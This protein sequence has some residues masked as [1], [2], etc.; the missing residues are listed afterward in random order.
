MKKSFIYL[1]TLTFIFASCKDFLSID[2]YFS[3]E[4]KL[5]SVFAEKRYVEAYLWAIAGEFTDEGSQLLNSYTPGPLATDEA[6]TVMNANAGYNGMQFVLGRVSA[7]NLYSLNQWASMYRVIRKC[8]TILNRIDEVQDMTIVERFK[9]TGNAR[10]MRAYAYYNILLNQGPPILLGDGVIENNE[11]LDFYNRGRC[12]CDEAVEYI[13]SEL[14]EAALYMDATVPILNFGRPTKG[15]AYGLIA[16][17]RLY[18]ASPLFNG[19]DAARRVFGAW[20]RKSDGVH[21]VSQVPDERR[22]ALAAA[23]AKRVMDMGYYRLYTVPAAAP[24]SSSAPK[25]MPANITLDTDYYKPWPEGAAGIDHFKS[26]SEIFNGEAIASTNP[27]FVWARNSATLTNNTRGSFPNTNGGWNGMS[28]TQKVIDAFSMFDGRAINNSSSEYPYSETGFSSSPEYFSEYQLNTNVYNMYINREMR[29]YASIGFTNCYWSLASTTDAVTKNIEYLFDG[30]NG[31]NSS[32]DPLNYPPT[33][34]VIKKFIHPMDAWNGNNARR[35]PKAYAMIRYADILLMY[36]EAL[37]NLTQTHSIEVNGE[38]QTFS[39]DRDAI[40][41]AFN[42]VRHRAGLPGLTNAEL[43]EPSTI[44]RLI[45]RERMVELLFEN[46]RYFDVRRWGKYEESENVMITGMNVEGTA[47]SYF[48]R[49]I[50]NTSLIGAR[51]VHKK[52]HL[53]PLPLD[54]VRRLPLLDQNPGWEE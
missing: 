22:W 13:C 20:K 28:V 5:D 40:R 38:F 39:R 32:S 4:L 49:T 36:A 37:N 29:F 6:F 52:L 34:Y 16:R 51:I 27:E 53:V 31:K 3:D 10:F 42:Q 41:Q 12:T 48:R 44:Q 47:G 54:E 1:I 23:A 14:E 11:T 18:H 19:G 50:P 30:N 35:L 17:L 33:G 15:A 26:C 45:E 43:A 2:N 46:H 7:S 8:N 25:T 24:T 9:I 21:Y